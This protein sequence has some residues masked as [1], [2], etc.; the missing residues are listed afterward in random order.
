M[1]HLKRL[2]LAFPYFERVP[3][4]QLVLAPEGQRYERVA[5]TRSSDYALLYIYTGAPVTVD[6]SRIAGRTKRAAWY[7]PRD[8]RL[9]PIGTTRAASATWQPPVAGQDWVLI[10]TEAEK[11]T[12]RGS[13]R[14]EKMG[15]GSASIA[16]LK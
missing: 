10:I 15:N 5:A 1:R 12:S 9:T 11:T 2:M 13:G 4:Q 16:H 14:N 3:D 7:S 6:L 8:G